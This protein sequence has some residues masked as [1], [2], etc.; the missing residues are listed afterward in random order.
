MKIGIITIY[1]VYNYGAMLQAYALKEF[2]KKNKFLVKI[3]EYRPYFID[4][5]Y[6]FYIKNAVVLPG[7]FLKD[8]L[9]INHINRDTFEDFLTNKI[10]SKKT[11]DSLKKQIKKEQY[12]CLISGSDQIW[13]PNITGN[14]KNYLM[15][16]ANK[17]LLKKISYA[18]SIGE[19][20]S[21]EWEKTITSQ[22][23]KYNYISVR[24]RDTAY[25]LERLLGRKV[26]YVVDPTMLLLPE[27]WRNLA[28]KP[29][30]NLIRKPYILV[31]Q[32]EPND[33]LDNCINRYK[34][35][36]QLSVISIH[37]FKK[38]NNNA[39]LVLNDIGP[40][41]FLW[42]VDNAESVF[43]NSFHGVVFSI[44][45]EKKFKVIHHTKSGIRTKNLIDEIQIEE[46]GD[47]FYSINNKNKKILK[48]MIKFSQEWLLDAIKN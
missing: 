30:T 9:H 25:K 37:P 39:T 41:E 13:N 48:N 38:E 35:K 11:H 27:D 47:G 12:D 1:F 16:F 20:I 22:L 10:E 43:T 2:L 42:L 4:K 36:S 17:F 21:P 45:F 19:T 26:T 33:Q 23:N 7:K 15:A 14:D 32:L 34:L 46:D 31:Y 6:R 24:E 18:S 8:L 5:N 29:E 3:L 28:R 44:L 40:Q